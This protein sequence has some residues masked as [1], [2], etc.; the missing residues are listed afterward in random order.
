MCK[1]FYVAVT[2]AKKYLYL[3][4]SETSRDKHVSTFLLEAVV[5]FYA[6]EIIFCGFTQ[7]K[8]KS[9]NLTKS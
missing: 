3:S 2:R 6:T 7:R 4:K 8:S 1:V 9:S 5:I